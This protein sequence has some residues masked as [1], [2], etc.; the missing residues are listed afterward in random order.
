MGGSGSPISTL[1]LNLEALYAL[2][3]DDAK[4]S[5]R[6]VKLRFVDDNVRCA[7]VV[8]FC[9]GSSDKKYVAV[10]S[11]LSKLLDLLEAWA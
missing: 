9:P 4:L 3:S 5:A 11:L 7:A 8:L 2:L 1:T 6:P 10:V